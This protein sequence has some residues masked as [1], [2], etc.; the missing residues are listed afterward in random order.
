MILHFYSP[1]AYG[2]VRQKF[3]KALPHPNTLRSW[4]SSIDGTPGFTFES[5]D[6]LKQKVIAAKKSNKKVLVVFMLDEISI[7]K[8]LRLPNGKICGYADFGFE[9]ESSD[10]ILLAK[11]A[12]VMMVVSLDESWKI[13]LGYF[14]IN[15]I[16]SVTNSGLIREAL[17]R[18][19]EIEVEVVSLTLEVHRNT[20]QQC[21]LLVRLSNC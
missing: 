1:K 11:D 12:L 13:P 8:S 2:F 3:C 16:N 10:T 21:A 15:G 17:I 9:I 20:S 5:F 4:Y 18:L 6:A 7:K 14:S 19:Y